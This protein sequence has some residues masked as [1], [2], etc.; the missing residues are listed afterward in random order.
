MLSPRQSVLPNRIEGADMTGASTIDRRQ[1]LDETGL[2]L[3]FRTARSHNGWRA[4]PISEDAIR[5]IYELA[6]MGP[7]S[8]NGNP[9]RF[10]WA[11]SSAAKERVAACVM[12]ANKPKVLSAPVVAIIGF[13]TE[14][15]RNFDYLMPFAPDK[16]RNVYEGSVQLRYDTAFRNSSLQG[17]TMTADRCQGSTTR[18]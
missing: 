10:I 14:F 4:D 13:D 7:T 3:L 6:K 17:W 15:H 5:K 11:R 12:D 2:D 8:T 9:A 16:Y 18:R 1:P